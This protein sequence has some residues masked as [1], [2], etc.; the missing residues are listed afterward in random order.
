MKKSRLL[1]LSGLE[2]D[3]LLVP[4]LH[5]VITAT[6]LTVILNMTFSDRFYSLQRYPINKKEV[7]IEIC[8]SLSDV[9]VPYLKS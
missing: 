2:L 9:V 1:L 5:S 3:L 8:Y 6:S 7:S 4:A